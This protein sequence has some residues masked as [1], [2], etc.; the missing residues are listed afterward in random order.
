MDI[1]AN[2]TDR[3]LD[4]YNAT[5]RGDLGAAQEIAN[6]L[7]PEEYQLLMAAGFRAAIDGRIP[8]EA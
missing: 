2:M 1:T 5:L 7:T 3:T 8:K 4:A 6:Q